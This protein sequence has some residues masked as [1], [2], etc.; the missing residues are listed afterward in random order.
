MNTYKSLSRIMSVCLDNFHSL[1]NIKMVTHNL[2]TVDI[3]IVGTFIIQND[4]M[5]LQEAD[6]LIF[7]EAEELM[8]NSDEYTSLYE[9]FVNTLFSNDSK[10]Q[11]LDRD[12]VVIYEYFSENNIIDIEKIAQYDQMMRE[13]YFGEVSETPKITDDFVFVDEENN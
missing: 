10:L 3:A 8:I 11:G 6:K 9:C 12:L 2:P 7:K 5:T 1:K 4:L 13:R